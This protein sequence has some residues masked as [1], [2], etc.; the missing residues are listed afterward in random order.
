MGGV[1]AGFDTRAN[2]YD[3]SPVVVDR[4]DGEVFVD[5]WMGVIN[6]NWNGYKVNWTY[7]PF[8]DWGE[9]LG[10]EPVS[11][12][13]VQRQSGYESCGGRVPQSY[14]TYLPREETF[15]LSTNKNCANKFLKMQGNV[16][17]ASNS[18]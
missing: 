3:P 7:V 16:C 9:G 8:N 2:C 15:Y 6:S 14:K 4:L 10:I 5:K 13:P 12:N 17:E 11:N 1:S 18:R